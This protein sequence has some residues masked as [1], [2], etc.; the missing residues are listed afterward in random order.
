MQNIWIHSAWARMCI[1]EE[2][3]GKLNRDSWK[4]IKLNTR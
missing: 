3:G 4:K 1:R 2:E